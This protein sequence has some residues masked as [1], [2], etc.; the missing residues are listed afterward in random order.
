MRTANCTIRE[1]DRLLRARSAIVIPGGMYG[2]LSTALLPGEYPQFFT[3]AHGAH[4]WDADGN[5]YLDLMC[6][7]GPQL[8]GAGYAPIEEAFLS[9]LTTG[10]L[11]PG[12]GPVM[13]ELAEAMVGLVGHADWA[14][15]CKDGGD[16]TTMALMVAR[17]CTGRSTIIRATGSY[18]G[19]LPW[20]TP[21]PAGTTSADRANQLFCRYNDIASLEA[22][23]LQAG[24]DLAAII[25]APIRHDAFVDQALPDTAYLR[26]IRS[27]CDERGALMIVD[28]VRAG[29]RL[30]RECS[31]APLGIRPDL[32]CW[33][34]ALGNGHPIS[35][36]L[37][38]DRARDAAS[39]IYVTGS[40]WY[41]AAA[42][43][44]ALA[45]L[46][47]VRGSDYLERTV[48]L[49]ERLRAGLDERARSC[50]FG[51]RQ[52]GPVQMPL[53]LFEED[54]DFR[55]GFC[56]SGEM[57]LRG[58]YVHPWHN[59]FISAA[60]TPADVDAVLDAAEGAFGALRAR[61]AS[62]SAPAQLRSLAG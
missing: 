55:L 16:T 35:A 26:R 50:G 19:S 58:V 49:G 10:D 59:M 56:W 14:M 54:P 48:S 24:G 7:Y 61:R 1:Q 11:A 9:Q 15:F 38:N 23:L 13:V 41:A 47:E 17:A 22:A 27:A 57:V 30:A 37:G 20:C 12:P 34:K 46:R 53:F 5:R 40:F 31:I 52:S 6:A 29:L 2:H 3:R 43:A 8:F 39:S 4:V 21:R 62:L 36:L 42:M 45:T 18:H 25:T 51:L 28:D 32:S 33:G 44:A 60:L